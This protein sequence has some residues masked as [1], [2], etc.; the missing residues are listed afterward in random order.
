MTLLGL[1][2]VLMAKLSGNEDIVFGTAS[3]GRNHVDLQTMVGMFINVLCMRNFPA[4]EKQF[5]DFLIEIKGRV[6]QASQNQDYQFEALVE[7]SG[8]PRDPSRHPIFDVGLELQGEEWAVASG[9]NSS[10]QLPG[11]VLKPFF[12]KNK[13]SR[14]DLLFFIKDIADH[15]EFE[16]EYSTRLFREETIRNFM[17][18]FKTILSVVSN[19][20][21]KKIGEIEILPAEEIREMIEG[22]QEKNK[23]MDIEFDFQIG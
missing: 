20:P 23:E 6:L 12:Y 18:Y 17:N 9:G 21:G 10:I 13:V 2:N 19:N 15:L 16:V 4:R 14:V 5:C 22:I 7:K 3:S 8:F 1:L 11:L